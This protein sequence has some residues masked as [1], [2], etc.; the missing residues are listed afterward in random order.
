MKRTNVVLDEH[1]LEEAVKIS[2]E[3]TYAR[4]IERA[5]REMVRRAQTVQGIEQL[6]GSGLWT[7]NLSEMRGDRPA[8][9]QESHGVYGPRKRPLTPSV[10]ED[11]VDLYRRARRA[12]FTIRSSVDCLIGSCAARHR[13]TVVHRHRDYAA[14][15]K[16]GAIEHVDIGPYLS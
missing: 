16:V 4:T 2:G 15:A 14:L 10:V 6:A 13:L 7:G 12:G 9:A 1:L 5:L 8:A 3:R 11:A